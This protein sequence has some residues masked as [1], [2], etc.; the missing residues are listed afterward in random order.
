VTKCTGEDSGTGDSPVRVREVLSEEK[1]CS[2]SRRILAG[3]VG[4]ARAVSKE[5]GCTGE[6]VRVRCTGEGVRVRSSDIGG[7]GG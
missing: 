1:G 5:G 4:G 7:G 3:A 6:G 2:R